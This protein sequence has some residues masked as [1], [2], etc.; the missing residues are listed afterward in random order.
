MEMKPLKYDDSIVS[1]M[2]ATEKEAYINDTSKY[3]IV[4]FKAK[5]DPTN[6]WA[7]PF[8]TGKKYK[9][10]W[11]NGLDFTKMQIDLSERWTAT[12]KDL[13]LIMNFTDVREAVEVKTAGELIPNMTLVNKT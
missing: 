9:I 13:Y 5:L 6:A 12:D 1:A 4:P 3:G 11:R 2:T 8:V 7:T 10:H